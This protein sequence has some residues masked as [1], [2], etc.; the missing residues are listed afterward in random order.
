MGWLCNDRDK[1]LRQ[2]VSNARGRLNAVTNADIRAGRRY[3]SDDFCAA[4]KDVHTT[5][6]QLPWW[7][8]LGA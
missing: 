4:T 5:E 1:L 2:Q 3:E 7:K 8:R 6:A